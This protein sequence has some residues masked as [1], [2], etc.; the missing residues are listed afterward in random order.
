MQNILEKTHSKSSFFLNSSGVEDG[1]DTIQQKR[2]SVF[3]REII[4]L[5]CQ[6]VVD[7]VDDEQGHGQK[8]VLGNFDFGA[9]PVI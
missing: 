2:R 3:L 1:N 4:Y 9:F 6:C 7:V 5:C 8:K